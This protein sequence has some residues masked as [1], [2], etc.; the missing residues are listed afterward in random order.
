MTK[1]DALRALKNLLIDNRSLTIHLPRT[2]LSE[3]A[4]EAVRALEERGYATK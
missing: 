3:K 1:R 2:V 4:Q